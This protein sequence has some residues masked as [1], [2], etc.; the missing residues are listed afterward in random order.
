MAS[1]TFYNAWGPTATVKGYSARYH[2]NHLKVDWSSNDSQ[3]TYTINAYA[4]SGNGSGSY[5]A[6][7]YTVNVTL[8]YSLNNGSNWISLGSA[9]GTLNYNN[10]VADITKTVTIN[11]TTTSQTIQFGAWNTGSS[12]NE[13]WHTTGND[14]IGALASYTVSYNANGGSGAPGNQT[15]YYGQDLTLSNVAPSRSN[16]TQNGY[17]VI[18]NSNGAGYANVS[19]T[20][21]NTTSYTFA[22]KWNTNS[23]GT[24]TEYAKGG[25]YRGNAAL[26]L[27]AQWTPSPSL[28]SVS[29]PTEM[30]KRD[31]YTFLGWKTDPTVTAYTVTAAATTYTPDGNK[32]LYAIWKQ[33]YIPVSLT[34]IKAIRVGETAST[35]P[36]DEGTI[37]YVT[38][39][40]TKGHA[41]NDTEFNAKEILYRC[42]DYGETA[43]TT[44][45]ITIPDNTT[46]TTSFW[47]DN[48]SIEKSWNIT[49]TTTDRHDESKSSKTTLLSPAFFTMDFL[50]GGR[51]IAFGKP[52]TEAILDIALP[53]KITSTAT[54]ALNIDGNTAINGT[55]T[56]NNYPVDFYNFG[57]TPVTLKSR[58]VMYIEGAKGDVAIYAPKL[59][60]GSNQ[61]NPILGLQTKG[62]GVW[63]FG[64]YDGESFKFCYHSQSTIAANTNGP[65]RQIQFN[66][67][68]TA[69]GFVVNDML[70][71]VLYNNTSGTTGNVSL[72]QSAANFTRLRIFA[73]LSNCG[74]TSI[75]VYSPNGKTFTLTGGAY[76]SSASTY[77]QQYAQYKIN[78][79]TITRNNG[80]YMNSM[81]H[82]SG[83]HTG[84]VASDSS[85]CTVIRVEGYKW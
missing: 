78:T 35:T 43:V 74:Y 29:I 10:N 17:T 52:A 46:T 8:Y 53:T 68:G 60:T 72:S 14:T 65:D 24:G 73:N 44:G 77:Q 26:T 5:Y 41:D 20:A 48:L 64:N 83:N 38:V 9:S 31:G 42:T 62:G 56:L 40:W 18:F 19:V 32:T 84:A 55:F 3:V 37:G 66:A 15:K 61:W 76:I 12:L 30:K 58:S 23:T 80:W 81:A 47:I 75:D 2:Q 1:G 82:S 63:T 36:A 54:T 45:T 71:T 33:N 79:T 11:R 51:G 57:E 70:P 13:A 85:N 28:G 7:G 6:S 67:D 59:A 21:K 39:N 25:T 16:S 50:K 4:R 27:Y 22:D 49:V 69:S 34:N